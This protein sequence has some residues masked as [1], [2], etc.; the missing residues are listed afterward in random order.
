VTENMSKIRYMEDF[1]DNSYTHSRWFRHRRDQLSWFPNREWTYL[2][3]TDQLPTGFISRPVP[4]LLLGY[5]GDLDP[6]VIYGD[7]YDPM[8]NRGLYLE[9]ARLRD[10]VI[11]AGNGFEETE[12]VIA[13][14][15]AF[16]IKYGMLGGWC[17]A[18]LMEND[19]KDAIPV[20]PL[21]IWLN[22]AHWLSLLLELWVSIKDEHTILK[23]RIVFGRESISYDPEGIDYRGTRV[24]PVVICDRDVNGEAFE[25][26]RRH[27]RDF[28]SPASTLLHDFLSYK[29]RGAVDLSYRRDGI[30]GSH[31]RKMIPTSLIG[32]IWL[33][34]SDAVEDGKTPYSCV[35]CGRLYRPNKSHQRTCSGK[36]RTRKQR[37]K[38]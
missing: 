24:K 8:E 23:R 21:S 13:V 11:K 33:Q 15:T 3:P 31:T 7:M 35:V 1:R 28:L 26:F 5:V 32:A 14:I 2:A 6:D 29:L 18:T 25:L 16:A 12:E 30:G 20:E 27:T 17:G 36:C 22:E 38:K 19:K 4:G 10:E 34:F 37:M 9:F